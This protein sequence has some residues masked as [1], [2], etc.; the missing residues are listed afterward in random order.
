MYISI[1]KKKI[2]SIIIVFACLFSLVGCGSDDTDTTDSTKIAITEKNYSSYITITSTYK[3]FHDVIDGHYE[4]VDYYINIKSKNK[5]Y[6]FDN[7][8]ITFSGNDIDS[9]ETILLSSTGTGSLTYPMLY[10]SYNTRPKYK[11]YM[12]SG[13]VYS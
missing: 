5:K 10:K 11:I 4:E 6:R 13:Y 2:S 3:I 8:Q 1:I 9:N 12:V 7:V